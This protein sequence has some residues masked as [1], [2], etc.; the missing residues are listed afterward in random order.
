MGF[1]LEIGPH[2]ATGRVPVR[3]PDKSDHLTPRSKLTGLFAIV[4]PASGAHGET[5]S[6]SAAADLHRLPGGVLDLSA[7]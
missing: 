4:Q 3:R 1:R 6:G 2:R 7:L 5:W